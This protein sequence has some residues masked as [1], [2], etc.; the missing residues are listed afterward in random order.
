MILA[1]VASCV[2]L[3][4]TFVPLHVWS[5]TRRVAVRLQAAFAVIGDPK[6]SDEE[7]EL[8]LRKRS[9]EVLRDTVLLV[10]ALAA[11]LAAAMLPIYLGE[12]AGWFT[13]QEFLVFTVQPL[14][15]I[16]TITAF[17]G[18]ERAAKIIHRRG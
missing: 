17:V 10:A 9:I 7:K 2:L 18:F 5:L 8:A 3:A 6:L 12:A 16:L 4:I 11:T 13:Y 14:V 15:I 1:Y